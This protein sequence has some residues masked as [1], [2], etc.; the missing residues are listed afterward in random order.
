M[1]NGSLEDWLQQER[2]G[3]AEG[4]SAPLRILNLLQRIHFAA[5]VSFA[6]EYLHHYCGTAII[7]CDLKPSN[8]LLDDELVAHVGDFGLAKFL[9][10]GITSSHANQSS[11]IGVRGTIGYAPPEYGLGNEP[12]TQGDVYSFGIL[13]LEMFTGKKPTDNRLKEGMSLHGF[14]KVAWP[15]RVME[16]VDH[17][18]LE[19]IVGEEI[20]AS[21]TDHTHHLLRT[22]KSKLMLEAVTSVLGIAL[23]CSVEFPQERMDMKDV[24]AKLSV[25]R[26][27]LLGTHLARQRQIPTGAQGY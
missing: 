10:S 7:H 12:S 11:S 5:D 9:S 15:E 6:L 17:A 23:S 13:L 18:V 20:N 1:A 22:G 27:K 21:T 14:V 8:V 24:A 16:I 4:T 19:D 25:I 26:N 2:T 3:S